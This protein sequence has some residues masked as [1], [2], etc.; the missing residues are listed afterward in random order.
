MAYIPVIR[1][2]QSC[3][4]HG[5]GW[6]CSS[7]SSK[8]VWFMIVIDITWQGAKGV[9]VV[10]VTPGSES[11]LALMCKQELSNDNSFLFSFNSSFPLLGGSAVGALQLYLGHEGKDLIITA[12]I[13]RQTTGTRVCDLKVSLAAFLCKA[14]KYCAYSRKTAAFSPA[15]DTQSGEQVSNQAEHFA[16]VTSGRGPQA[17]DCVHT[18]T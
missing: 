5:L 11:R 14:H 4:S 6:A 16:A 1:I 2:D 13:Y 9:S 10:Q 8:V 12:N 7:Y 17:K 15:N 3:K 18:D